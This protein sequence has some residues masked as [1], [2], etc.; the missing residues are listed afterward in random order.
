MRVVLQRVSEASVLANGALVGQIGS[1]LLILVGIEVSDNE[2]DAVW[3]ASKTVAL[4]IFDDSDKIP[5][6]S[7]KETDGNLLLVSQFTLHS[8]TKK[9][10]RP[11]YIKAARP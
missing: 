4:R 8:L 9:G 10:N 2:D 3:I 11:S 6:L 7:L 5:N 1:G